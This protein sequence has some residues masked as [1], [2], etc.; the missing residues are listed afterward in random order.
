MNWLDLTVVGALAGGLLFGAQRGI[1]RQSALIVGFYVSLVLAARYYGQ[2]AGLLV[3]Y[4]PQ[5]DPAV[6]SAYV[7]A[8]LTAGGTLAL[9]WLPQGVY[10]RG[11]VS[12]APPLARV[13]RG[14]RRAAPA[15]AGARLAA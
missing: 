10:G 12:R 3:A 8:G 4:V 14:R 9:G 5:A 6:A 15:R 11:G 2:A 1:L 13:G 7:L